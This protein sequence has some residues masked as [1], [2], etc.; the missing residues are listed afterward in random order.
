MLI[1]ITG[2]KGSGKD[3]FAQPFINHGAINVK[4][5]ATLKNMLRS[6]CLT[7]G[8]DQQEIEWMLEGDLKEVPCEVFGGKTPRWAMQTLGTEWRNMLHKDLWLNIWKRQVRTYLERGDMVICT[9]I[10]F[11]HEYE[12]LKEL[13]GSLVRVDRVG[14]AG[15]DTHPSETEMMA[16]PADV[17]ITNDKGITALHQKAMELRRD[18]QS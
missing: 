6:M 18:Y 4:M 5:A 10:R 13:G 3:T 8:V 11:K 7:A 1:G 9:D 12:A 16:L 14:L 17:L 15:G 2:A